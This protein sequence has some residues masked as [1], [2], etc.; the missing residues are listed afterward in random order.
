MAHALTTRQNGMTEMFA[1]GAEPWHGLG[2][3]I[4]HVATAKEAIQLGGLDWKTIMEPVITAG[5]QVLE[6]KYITLREDNGQPLG[7]VGSKYEILQNSKAFQFMDAVTQDPGGPKYH[8]A[9]S[10]FGGRKI[11]LLAKMP[12][13]IEVTKD[14][15]VEE[16]LLLSNSHDGTKA[17]NVMPTPIR[18]VCNNTLSRAHRLE[19]KARKGFKIRHSGDILNKVNNVQDALGIIRQTFVETGEIYKALAK[20]EPTKAQVDEVLN[21]LF[22]ET[23]SARSSLQKERVLELAETGI[24][25]GSRNNLGTAWALYNGITELVDHREGMGAKGPDAADSRLNRIW[26][27]SGA[28][29]KTE[30]LETLVSVCLN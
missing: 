26:F 22:P 6:G 8:T 19:Q 9:G 14:D 1:Y 20:V 30:A 12:D 13:F 17:V 5:G 15:I 3:R 11:W 27:G 7:V 23:K 29:F 18:V 2:Q 25:N 24:G 10:L 21:R 28:E 4:D 16:Y